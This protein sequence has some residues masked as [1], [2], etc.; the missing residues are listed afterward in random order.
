MSTNDKDLK[1]KEKLFTASDIKGVLR[2]IE[3]DFLD[4]NVFEGKQKLFLLNKILEETQIPIGIQ[5]ISSDSALMVQNLFH[6][7]INGGRAGL[8]F[9]ADSSGS[10]ASLLQAVK[11]LIFEATNW[12]IEEY[13]ARAGLKLKSSDKNP[14]K[15][16]DLHKQLFYVYLA[17][18]NLE[19][20]TFSLPIIPVGEILEKLDQKS[21]IFIISSGG[22]FYIFQI[23]LSGWGNETVTGTV[24]NA[25]DT[26]QYS[27][28]LTAKLGKRKKNEEIPS[29]EYLQAFTE[30]LY[31]TVKTDLENLENLVQKTEGLT[32]TDFKSVTHDRI[33]SV[34]SLLKIFYEVVKSKNNKNSEETDD[35]STTS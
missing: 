19:D 13:L 31:E 24:I 32:P 9:R 14:E 8:N 25:E 2:E 35:A 18:N 12:K 4:N 15:L 30:K 20:P 33:R 7:R 16:T 17:Q 10:T 3:Q 28:N 11:S 29:L 34:G 6:L 1:T 26:I 22:E 5:A 21:K 23:E 27:A